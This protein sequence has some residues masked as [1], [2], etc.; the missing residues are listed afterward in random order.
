M[1]FFFFFLMIR[2]P[3]RSTLFPY[4]TLFRSPQATRV[5]STPEGRSHAAATAT[6]PEAAVRDPDGRLVDA[7]ERVPREAPRA[8]RQALHDPPRRHPALRDALRPGRDQG[9]LPGTAGRPPPGRGGEDPRAGGRQSVGDSSRRG[10]A[11]RAAQTP[12]PRLPRQ[13]DAG[14]DGP[15]DGGDRARGGEVAARSAPAAAP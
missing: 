11:P 6:R 10:S 3:P 9:G 4:T 15:R 5:A 12:P 1:L 8:L 14:A 2:R 7:P 13:E